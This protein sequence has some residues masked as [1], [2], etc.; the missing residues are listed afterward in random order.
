MGWQDSPKKT[1]TCGED[2]AAHRRVKLKSGTTT[3]P[4]E[5]EYADAGEDFIGVTEFAE[6]SGELIT[7]RLKN[8][9]GTVEIEAS[10]VA[11]IGADLYG[12]ADGKLSTTI[13]G[14]VQA[15]ALEASGAGGDVIEVLLV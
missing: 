10:T 9:P 14:S 13:N 5:V 7:V 8:A 15:E 1:F 6:S 3:Q 2:L 4:P 11:A 12:A